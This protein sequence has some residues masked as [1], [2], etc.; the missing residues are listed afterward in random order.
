MGSR[1]RQ[2]TRP[3]TGSTLPT[4]RRRAGPGSTTG[5]PGA[6]PIRL[7]G[8]KRLFLPLRTGSGP[9]GVLGIDRD[10]PGPLLTPDERRLL[11]ALCRPGGGR[12]RAHLAGARARRGAGAGRDRA[13]A[14]RAADLD[15]AR[16]AHARSPRSSARFRACAAFPR[17]MA[18]PNARNCSRR[19]R[20][21]PSA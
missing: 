3:R 12:D 8:G 17:N 15:L 7:P 20:K 5:R 19:C 1:S 14:R 6:A 4:W 18:R 10:A 21:K 9:V 2:A 11:D 13:A 16:S